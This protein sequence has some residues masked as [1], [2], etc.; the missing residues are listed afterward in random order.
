[1][2]KFI[3]NKE[4]CAKTVEVGTEF[5]REKVNYGFITHNDIFICKIIEK[6]GATIT[7]TQTLYHPGFSCHGRVCAIRTAKIMRGKLRFEYDNNYNEYSKICKVGEYE[8]N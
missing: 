1:M 5:M 4:L 7:F 8:Y 2:K 6:K 3:S